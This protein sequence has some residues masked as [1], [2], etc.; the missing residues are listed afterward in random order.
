ML[1]T[2]AK[3]P[4]YLSENSLCQV[5]DLDQLV[6]KAVPAKNFNLLITFPD[7]HQFL[8]KQERHNQQGNTANEFER[9]YR[10]QDFVKE[11][12]LGENFN[13]VL[14]KV[15]HFDR[16]NS[17]IVFNY[18]NEYRDLSE[19]Y[20]QENNFSPQIAAT[21]GKI[22]SSIHKTTFN[23]SQY[24]DFFSRDQERKTLNRV[25]QAGESFTRITPEIFGLVPADGLKFFS[26]YQRYDSLGQAIN[27]LGE[28][29]TP[30][31]LTHNDLKLNNVLIHNNW[32]TEE[33]TESIIRIIDWERSEWGDPAF[34]L[35]TLIASYVQMWLGSLVISSSL[36]I[37]ESLKLATIPLE[38]LQP[39]MASLTISYLE[40]F[41]EI[42]QQRPDFLKRTIQN[43]GFVLIVNIQAMIQYQKHF[44]NLGIGMLQVAKS[45][46]CRPEAAMNTLF[47]SDCA[48]I[49]QFNHA[50]V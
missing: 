17:I 29:F 2:S 27:E 26:L 15:V 1:L 49:T 36:T 14:P 47:G 20:Q 39:A 18:L 11:F 33:L 7:N 37:E 21:L 5:S 22:I 25:T 44:G 10:I 32:D 35:G 31:C 9:E 23:Q 43:S 12:N 4:E 16:D 13:S 28:A 40:T 48:K 46:L 45:L 24:Q 50:T 41:P 30:S 38:V 3:V 19:F 8:V 34:D 42:I 6:I